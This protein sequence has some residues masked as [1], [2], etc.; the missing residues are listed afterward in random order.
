[1]GEDVLRNQLPEGFFDMACRW[2]R[3]LGYSLRVSSPRKTK[4]GDFRVDPRTGKHRI[5]VNRTSNK[6]LFLITLAHE[7]A[8]SEVQH[9]YGPKVSHH[10]KEW[11]AAFKRYL[12]EII[13]TGKVPGKLSQAL[14]AYSK[15]P[16]ASTYSFPP[17]VRAL[18]AIEGRDIRMLESLSPGKSFYLNG[19]K[20]TYLSQKRTRALCRQEITGRKYLI[21]L[22]AEILDD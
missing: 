7:V 3:E 15:N 5:S 16:R 10:G 2:Q 12:L 8:H 6:W 22:Q 11:K 9:R 21:S 13:S 17:L 20:Y 1:M 4:L 14:A 18:N 19:K